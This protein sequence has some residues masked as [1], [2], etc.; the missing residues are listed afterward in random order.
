MTRCTATHPDGRRCLLP[1]HTGR[2]LIAESEPASRA[3]R[4]RVAAAWRYPALAKYRDLT[5][6]LLASTCH[7]L[8]E[9]GLDGEKARVDWAPGETLLSPSM[10]W[11]VVGE[12]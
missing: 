11:V 3:L 7:W 8:S 6:E 5:A 2:H 10:P 12:A 4:D 1:S 9:G